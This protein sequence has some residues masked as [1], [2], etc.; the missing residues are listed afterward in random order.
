MCPCQLCATSRFCSFE[1]RSGHRSKISRE[2]KELPI[3]QNLKQVRSFTGLTSYY[4]KFIPAYSEVAGPLH[5]LTRKDVPFIWSEDCQ[6]AF[7]KLKESLCNPPILAYPDFSLPF[8]LDCDASGKSIGA[9]LS[10]VQGGKERVIA[11][12]SKSC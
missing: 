5:K 4:R 7:E 1:Q 8:I 12:A 9:V 11:Y 2:S 10:Q 6:L 3:P